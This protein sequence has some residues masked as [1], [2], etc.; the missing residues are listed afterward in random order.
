[1]CLSSK[2]IFLVNQNEWKQQSKLGGAILLICYVFD[3]RHVCCHVSSDGVYSHFGLGCFASAV[4][5]FLKCGLLK[6]NSKISKSF[7]PV[8]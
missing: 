4:P 2:H 1:M 3:L 6:V 7:Q 5:E 8:K